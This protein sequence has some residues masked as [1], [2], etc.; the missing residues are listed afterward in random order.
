MR[1]EKGDKV[2][3]TKCSFG[4]FAIGETF[5]V[6]EVDGDGDVVDKNGATH[7]NGNIC[8]VSRQEQKTSEDK[9]ME[10]EKMNKK[11]LAEAKKKFNEEKTSA[12]IEEAKKQYRQ[13]TDNI[14][15]LNR[16]IADREERKKPYLEVIAKFK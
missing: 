15:T 8:L 7:S 10:L 14:D 13:A 2:K 4:D 16:E 12:E 9:K 11:S 6:H 1:Y 5:E 3:R